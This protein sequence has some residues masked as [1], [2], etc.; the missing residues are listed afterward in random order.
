MIA[1]TL[2]ACLSILFSFLCS[3]LEAVLLSI[4]PIFLEIKKKENKPYAFTLEQLKKDIDQPLIAI[5]TLNTIAHTVG[6]IGVGATA[7]TAFGTGNNI[8][9]IVSAIMTILIL[10]V[11]EIIPKTIGATYW[12]QLAKFS[13]KTLNI[14]V[15]TLKYT[16]ILWLLQLTTQLIGKKS[17]H[18]LSISREDF[19]AMTDVAEKEGVFHPSESKIVRNLLRFKTIQAQ[20]IMTPRTVMFLAKDSLSIQEFYES[21]K[22]IIFSRIPIYEDQ[23]EQ[24]TGFVLK[25][26]LLEHLINQ[27]GNVSLKKISRTILQFP[28]TASL[29]TLFEKFLNNKNQIALVVDEYGTIDGLVTMEDVIET[30]IGSEIV[31]ET[32][33]IEDLQ[34][35]ARQKWEKRA[36]KLGIIK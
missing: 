33:Q 1:L 5:L 29:P 3:I 28:N 6:A 26:K 11:S 35:W 23:P 30:L 18:S 10:V 21:K 27:K 14:L 2:F 16:G 34:K 25:D 22:E 19:S 8:V 17:A 4:T 32:D 12:K 36:K 24:I 7:E 13:T 20:D 31:D 15:V 9:G